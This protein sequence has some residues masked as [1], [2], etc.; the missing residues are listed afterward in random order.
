ML[1]T[2]FVISGKVNKILRKNKQQSIFRNNFEASF[3][4][5][6]QEISML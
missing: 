1:S 4:E 3:I 6:F 5:H 2:K